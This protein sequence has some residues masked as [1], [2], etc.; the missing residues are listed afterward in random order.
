MAFK[1]AATMVCD[2]RDNPAFKNVD[3]KELQR[4]LIAEGCDLGI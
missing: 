1:V 2:M 3:V 4:E